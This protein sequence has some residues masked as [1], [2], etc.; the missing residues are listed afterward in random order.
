MDDTTISLFSAILGAIIGSVAAYYPAAIIARRQARVENAR[1]FVSSNYLPLLAAISLYKF[2]LALWAQATH[3]HDATNIA[4]HLRGH[5]RSVELLRSAVARIFDSGVPLVLFRIDPILHRLLMAVH[6]RFQTTVRTDVSEIE[7][8][9]LNPETIWELEDRLEALAI[10]KVVA[11]Y[12]RLMSDENKK[13]PVRSLL[14]DR[15]FAKAASTKAET[16][17]N[18]QS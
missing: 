6:A 7:K 17:A 4:A 12:E 1:E 14:D 9:G 11:E 15:R 16:T 2:T 10:P 13:A 18:P 8:V 3:E 5:V